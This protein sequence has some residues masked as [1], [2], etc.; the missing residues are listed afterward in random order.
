ML[1]FAHSHV[2]VPDYMSPFNCNK[3]ARGFF[4]AAVEELD[5]L[6]GS[7][8]QYVESLHIDQDTLVFFT[9]DNGPWMTQRLA[10]GSAALFRGAKQNTFEGVP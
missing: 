5:S 10:G 3:S 8:M 6:I 4:G 9:S 2:H 1:Y 7:V